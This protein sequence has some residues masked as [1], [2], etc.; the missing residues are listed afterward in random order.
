[1]TETM[2]KKDVPTC[3]LTNAD[4]ITLLAEPMPNETG[5]LLCSLTTRE[6]TQ[7]IPRGH[8]DDSIL[9]YTKKVA[10]A[11]EFCKEE[12]FSE[13]KFCQ[14]LRI[15]MKSGMA[16][17][18][19]NMPPEDQNVVEKVIAE[20]KEKLDRTPSEYLFLF[21]SAT[22]RPAESYAAFSMRLKRLYLSSSGGNNSGSQL[23][24][25]EK[26]ILVERFLSGL[27]ANESTALR[28]VA[29]DRESKDVEL[30][31]KRASRSRPGTKND[32]LICGIKTVEA[33]A[34]EARAVEVASKTEDDETQSSLHLEYESD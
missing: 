30:L 2:E 16:E 6:A 9:D 4:V 23:T 26:S 34:V 13:K 19:D 17:V 7:I 22:K 31:A 15:S 10:S 3:P 5:P 8:I 12:N 29:T 18:F 25:G 27:P 28:M 32:R 33:K 20:V 24:E 11:W 14:L 21:Q 1:M